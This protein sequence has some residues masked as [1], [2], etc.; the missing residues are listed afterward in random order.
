MAKFSGPIWQPFLHC[1]K[2]HAWKAPVGPLTQAFKGRGVA[3]LPAGRSGLEGGRGM[4]RTTQA[5]VAEAGQSTRQG[6]GPTAVGA[7]LSGQ[8]VLLHVTE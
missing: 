2:G 6:L 1:P 3:S 5:E 7:E 8:T 4:P